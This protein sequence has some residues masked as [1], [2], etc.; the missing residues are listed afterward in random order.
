VSECRIVLKTLY[1]SVSVE[2][3]LIYFMCQWV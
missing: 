1:V 2:L 3:F